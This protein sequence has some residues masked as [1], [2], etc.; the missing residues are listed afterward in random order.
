MPDILLDGERYTGLMGLVGRLEGSEIDP[1]LAAALIAFAFV[2][3]HPFGD[4]NGRIHRYLIHH[5]LDRT[6]F[7]PPG[8]LFPVSAS[9][10][11]SQGAYD[12]ALERFSR[13]IAPYLDWAWQ[14]GGSEEGPAITVRNRTGHLYRYFDATPQVEY[15][16]G[17][18]IDT[19][20]R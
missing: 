7:T 18:V 10:A 1:V 15:L 8:I 4:G 12:A 9:I 17:C 19:V 13:A 14:A 11:R 5:T 3:I 16:Y 2:F 20:R 6:G